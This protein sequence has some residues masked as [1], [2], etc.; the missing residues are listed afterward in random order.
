MRKVILEEWV[1][2]DGYAADASQGPSFVESLAVHEYSEKDQ[3]D[4]LDWIDNILLG[5]NTY[6]L[7]VDFWPAATRTQEAIADKLNRIPQNRLF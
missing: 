7:F 3:S 4:F 1:S 5:A 2:L 6:R